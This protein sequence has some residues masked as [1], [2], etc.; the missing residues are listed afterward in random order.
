MEPLASC[1]QWLNED[2]L[3]D[4]PKETVAI[5]RLDK[6]IACVWNNENDSHSWEQFFLLSLNKCIEF[7][8][9][10]LPFAH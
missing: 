7:G 10:L 1:I 9:T 6:K 5:P 3:G 4:R 2:E 8:N